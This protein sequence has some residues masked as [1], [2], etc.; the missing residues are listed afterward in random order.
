M[1]RRRPESRVRT[2]SG[3][4]HAR[5]GSRLT[6]TEEPG[7]GR[8][9]LGDREFLEIRDHHVA[10]AFD[11]AGKSGVC[12]WRASA[13]CYGG[14]GPVGEEPRLRRGA[15]GRFNMTLQQNCRQGK[16]LG[17]RKRAAVRGG[18]GCGGSAMGQSAELSCYL[19]SSRLAKKSGQ[20]SPLIIILVTYRR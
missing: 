10:E 12:S 13:V 9:G 5:R 15:H 2:S 8:V 19:A 6:E 18:V 14:G 3:G 4:P 17:G 11:G 16:V 20:P 7:S 1:A